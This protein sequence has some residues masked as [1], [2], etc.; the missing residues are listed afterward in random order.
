MTCP[1]SLNRR[2][3]IQQEFSTEDLQGGRSKT[4][5][6]IATVW[7]SSEPMAGRES[8]T[9]GKLLG[10]AT[11]VV[12]MRHRSDIRPKMRLLYGFRSFDITSVIDEHEAHRFL[13]LGCTERV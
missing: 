12:R 2:V 5:A 10:E 4:W 3:I 13:V 8:Y 7:A 1:S 11:Y 6:D 9:W